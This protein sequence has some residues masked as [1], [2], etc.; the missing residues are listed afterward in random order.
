MR[1]YPAVSHVAF[2]LFVVRV[3]AAPAS[4]ETKRDAPLYTP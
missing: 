2:V 1:Y 3:V 4:G